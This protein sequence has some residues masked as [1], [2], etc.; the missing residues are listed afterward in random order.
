M[1]Q[2]SS[3]KFLKDLKKNNHKEWFEANRKAYEATKE[4]FANFVNDVIAKHG[5]KD[6]TIVSLTAKVAIF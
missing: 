3:V 6:E 1:L 5:K 4:D 2:P